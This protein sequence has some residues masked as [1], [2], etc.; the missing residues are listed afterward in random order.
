MWTT[1]SS[2]LWRQPE[3]PCAQ[4]KEGLQEGAEDDSLPVV[5]WAAYNFMLSLAPKDRL[6]S[7]NILGRTE[8]I[9]A[10]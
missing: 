5:F 3:K 6:H 2:M 9:I 10:N 7:L 1:V 8:V 4:F